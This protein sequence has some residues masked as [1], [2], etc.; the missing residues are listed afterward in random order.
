MVLFSHPDAV[1]E[2]FACPG[3]RAGGQ[4]WEFLRPFAGRTRSCSSMGTSISASA[5]L[6]QAIPREPMRALGR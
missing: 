2:V 1:R 6:A 3:D 4:S 5:A